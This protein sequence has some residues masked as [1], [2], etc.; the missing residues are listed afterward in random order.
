MSQITREA[1]WEL[2][3]AHVSEPALI[4]HALSVEAVMRYFARR[5]GEDEREWG[6]IGLCHDVDYEEHPDEHLQ[7]AQRILREAAWPEPYI[8]AVLSHGWGLCTDVE[9]VSK[10][11][12]TLFT[13]DELTGLTAAAALVR[14]SKSVL[15]MHAKSVKKKWNTRA[16]S[17]GVDRSVIERGAKMLG[18]ELT[19]VIEWTIMGMREV[20]SEIGL[21]GTVSES[22]GGE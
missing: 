2:L 4:R 10:L 21:A 20:A 15:D 14:P 12:K 18:M 13:I 1:A 17:A 6:V 22:G 7:H 8:R 19:E 16:F 3:N 11:E 9:P 5:F